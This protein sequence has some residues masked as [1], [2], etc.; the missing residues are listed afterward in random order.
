M[1]RRLIHARH[2]FSF[3]AVSL[4]ATSSV[5]I[6]S[7][8]PANQNAPTANQQVEQVVQAARQ[9]R[10]ELFAART[11][12][13]VCGW[14]EPVGT[15]AVAIQD[16][17]LK[18]YAETLTSSME[19][20]IP[21][22]MPANCASDADRK[23]GLV[24]QRATF[25]WLTRLVMMHRI[26]A[27]PGWSNQIVILGNDAAGPEALWKKAETAI[28]PSVG[29]NAVKQFY[30]QVTNDSQVDAALI[31]PSRVN[32]STQV[33][34]VCPPVPGAQPLHTKLAA[35]KLALIERFAG[36]VIRSQKVAAAPPSLAQIMQPKAVEIKPAA[37]TGPL[38]Q[39]VK[40]LI[41]AATEKP[42]FKSLSRPAKVK[43][44]GIAGT[45]VPVG[46]DHCR[47]WLYN[48]PNI[49]DS[50]SCRVYSKGDNKP[51]KALSDSTAAEMTACLGVQPIAPGAMASRGYGHLIWTVPGVAGVTVYKVDGSDHGFT[52][53][54]VDKGQAPAAATAPAAAPASNPTPPASRQQPQ[55]TSGFDGPTTGPFCEAV[56]TILAKA[57]EKPRFSSISRPA[58]DGASAVQGTIIPNGF[59]A[60]SI[61]R[62]NLAMDKYTCY[63]EGFGKDASLK[64]SAKSQADLTAC[65]NAQPAP[66][67]EV[68]HEQVFWR[69]PGSKPKIEV[70]KK[71]DPAYAFVTMDV[72]VWWNGDDQPPPPWL[73][74][75]TA[76][77]APAAQP[78]PPV[79]AAP[80]QPQSSTSAAP[81]TGAL[82][83]GLKHLIGKAKSGEVPTFNSVS[84]KPGNSA[85]NVDGAYAL[86]GYENCSISRDSSPE[87]PDRYSC[88]SDKI[89]EAAARARGA[90][91][92]AELMACMGVE[93]YV[94]PPLAHAGGTHLIWKVSGANGVEVFMVD[95]GGAPYT[96]VGVEVHD[97]IVAANAIAAAAPAQPPTSKAG[98]Q[99]SFCSALK[100]IIDH[101]GTK[102]PFEPIVES[103]KI[104]EGT[105]TYIGKVVPPGFLRCTGVRVANDPGASDD[106]SCMAEFDEAAPIKERAAKMDAV[107]SA[108]LGAKPT[109]PD[110]FAKMFNK[111]EW[112]VKGKSGDAVVSRSYPD[113]GQTVFV[114]V[115]LATPHPPAKP[116]AANPA[117]VAP[118]PAVPAQPP[119]AASPPKAPARVAAPTPPATAV[120]PQA[121]PA[122]AMPKAGD[123]CQG[124]RQLIAKASAGE[125]PSFNSA[126]SQ[127]GSHNQGL[128]GTL[129]LPFYDKCSIW[130]YGGEKGMPDKYVCATNAIGD[131]RSRE[132][133]IATRAA[134]HAC[135]GSPPS[136]PPALAKTPGTHLVWKVAG[137]KAVEVFLTDR[138]GQPYTSIGVQV[139][140][141]GGAAPRQPATTSTR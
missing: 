74:S 19:P 100:T 118:V 132:R 52:G 63:S 54:S 17:W 47:V 62:I 30:Q 32:I 121:K 85:R 73:S 84:R 67:R 112:R 13:R 103:K 83:D 9:Q 69:M 4:I 108:C 94:P 114:T 72:T 75:R 6:A 14:E 136:V 124:I 65:F 95:R 128:L 109:D 49:D 137:S 98:D 53:L 91:T 41:A 86:P 24:M 119:Q 36:A 126:S 129:K 116:A 81:K 59:K 35:R 105:F 113:G 44:D 10:A 122:D 90:A 42:A 68:G 106:Y 127:P 130:R 76:T 48:S 135:M 71:I 64:L 61:T 7:A 28:L 25:E 38:C 87:I 141:D 79:A 1:L 80:A 45:L 40:K 66:S 138:P 33:P 111:T 125:V 43:A 104:A 117:T 55:Q 107:L 22:P 34:R 46:Y 12:S 123:L 15:E 11:Q 29:A 131:P 37:K 2:R 82:C 51:I 56:K 16:E 139:S 8:Q 70:S 88:V 50:Y 134:L 101:A 93:P 60:C 110:F 92:K 57:W 27:Q 3:L 140:A 5:T 78:P 96:S 115:K 133:A 58:N 23:A 20:P 120:A 31:C 77:P 89:G 99:Q 39:Q 21:A 26:A 18:F 102:P 97:Q